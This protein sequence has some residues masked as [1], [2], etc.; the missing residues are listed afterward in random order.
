[1]P[2][3]TTEMPLQISK[4]RTISV[5][6]TQ[7][8]EEYSIFSTDVRLSRTKRMKREVTATSTAACVVVFVDTNG[9]PVLISKSNEE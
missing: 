4:S 9:R 3:E 8:E 7:F 1:M 2:T 5:S 6:F